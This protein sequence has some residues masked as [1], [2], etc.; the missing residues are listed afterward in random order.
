MNVQ[1][2]EVIEFMRIGAIAVYENLHPPR[3]TPV[4]LDT[5]PEPTHKTIQ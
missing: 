1:L 4:S 2:E 3:R 5:I